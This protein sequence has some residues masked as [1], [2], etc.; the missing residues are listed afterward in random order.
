MTAHAA[1]RL[2]DQGKL[3]LDAPV[4]EYWPEF[5][6]AGKAETP[7]RWLLCHRAG[8]QAHRNWRPPVALSDWDAVC[9]AL[10]AETPWFTPGVGFA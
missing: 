3:D 10:A 5:G 6:Q 2:A 1:N 4:A 8:L 7:V 9:A